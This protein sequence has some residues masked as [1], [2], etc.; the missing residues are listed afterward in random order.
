MQ[1]ALDLKEGIVMLIGVVETISD[2]FQ[3]RKPKN[4]KGLGLFSFLGGTGV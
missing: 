3:R 4:I 2:F 1:I